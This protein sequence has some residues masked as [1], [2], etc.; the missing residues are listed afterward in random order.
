MS[1]FSDRKNHRLLLLKHQ[2]SSIRKIHLSSAL[3]L[4]KPNKKQLH[5]ADLRGQ[6]QHQINMDLP[7]WSDPDSPSYSE[8]MAG[9][10]AQ[11]WKHAMEEEFDSLMEHAVGTLV[12][13]PPNAN[14]LGGMWIFNKKRD[15]HNRIVRYKA[16]WVVLGNHQIKGLDCNDTYASVAKI[17][18]LRVLLALCVSKRPRRMKIRQFDIVTAFLNGDMKDLVYARQVLGFEHPTQ[19]H[20]VWLLI[21]SL[22]GTKQA[23]R[24]WQQHFGVTTAGFEIYPIS[25]DSAV[26]VLRCN[27]GLLILHLHVDDSLVFCDNDELFSKFQTFIN[28]KYKL[29]WTEKPTLYLGIKLDIADDGSYIKISQSHYIKSCLERFAM[30]NCKAAKTPLPQKTILSPGTSEE[31]EQAKDIPYQELV[32]CLQWI[33]ACA[34]PD[35]SYA[36][37]QL[38]KYNSAWTLAHWTAAKHVLRYL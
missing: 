31:I 29:K 12:D 4:S 25:S 27:L 18:S 2:L 3:R 13:P 38:S 10:D 14:I 22:Y 24:R 15:K 17:D 34:R 19:R 21:K 7:L 30:V 6:R 37:S 11:A 8:A 33:S 36:V 35:I 32:G 26:Y 16:Q 20:R 23:A 9:P 5:L 28:S 1:P